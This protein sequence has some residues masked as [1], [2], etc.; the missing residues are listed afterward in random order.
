M[1]FQWPEQNKTKIKL[2]TFGKYLYTNYDIVKKSVDITSYNIEYQKA[3]YN[4]H[5]IEPF[6]EYWICVSML[7]NNSKDKFSGN[8]DIYL[9]NYQLRN[10]NYN[11]LLYLFNKINFLFRKFYLIFLCK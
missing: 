2:N 5:R 9:E 1:L 7:L 11:L 10:G 3:R 4:K 8:E 6:E